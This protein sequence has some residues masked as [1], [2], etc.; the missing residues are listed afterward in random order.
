MARKLAMIS[1]KGGSGKTSFSLAFSKLLS[2]LGIKVLLIDCDMST[3]GATFFMKSNIEKHKNL[4]KS[5]V[6]VDDIL[7]ATSTPPYGFFAI[8]GRLYDNSYE[9]LKFSKLICVDREFYFLPSDVSISNDK[10]TPNKYSFN[11]FYLCLEKELDNDFDVI[12]FDCQA[13][14]SEFTRNLISVSDLVLLVTEPDSVSAAANRALCFQAGIELENVQAYQLFNKITHEEATYYSKISTS[15]FFI[16]ISSVVF[17]WAV[18]RTF[19]FC[20]LPSAETVSINFAKEIASALQTLFP[21]YREQINSYLQELTNFQHTLL[22]SQI[23]NTKKKRTY[24]SIRVILPLCCS[25]ALL[26]MFLV[27]VITQTNTSDNLIFYIFLGFFAGIL[28]AFAAEQFFRSKKSSYDDEDL[29]ILLESCGD[30]QYINGI[31]D[32]DEIME[33]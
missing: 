18:R 3:H 26:I 29:G 25:L 8:P 13:G 32:N 16:N 5:V 19:V 22:K 12:I 1:G 11:T 24:Q 14:F 17:N 30:V 10:P 2:D 9:S 4:H 33:S 7:L 20:E 15:A 27:L 23:N 21:E 28:L 31:F 6:S